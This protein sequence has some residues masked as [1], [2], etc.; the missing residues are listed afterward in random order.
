MI[1]RMFLSRLGAAAF[2]GFSGAERRVPD[3]SAA[4]GSESRWQ[5]ARH[6][7]D[8]WLDERPGR[9]RM[10][11]DALTPKGAEESLGYADNFFLANRSGYAIDSPDLAV[12]VCFRHHATTFAFNDAM[13]AKYGVAFAKAIG[14][15]DPKSGQ[16]PTANLHAADLSAAVKQ[17]VHFAVCDMASHY[18]SEVAATHT[19]GNADAVYKELKANAVAN[20]HFVAAGI[21]AVNRAQERGYSIAYVG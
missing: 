12:V 7:A 10:F 9:H 8:D 17:G 3:A 1:R 18:F 2:L 14:V 6:A 4:P 20:S 19:G 5:P 11:F 13:W 15:T 21:V 16:A